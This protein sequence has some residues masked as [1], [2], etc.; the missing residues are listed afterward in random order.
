LIIIKLTVTVIVFHHIYLS[1][2]RL[3][4]QLLLRS[5]ASME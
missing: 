3:I 4:V 1:H 5:V 2:L